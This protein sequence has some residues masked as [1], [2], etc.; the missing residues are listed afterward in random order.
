MP[1]MTVSPRCRPGCIAGI[2]MSLTSTSPD[3]QYFARERDHLSP[4]ARDI[5]PRQHRPRTLSRRLRA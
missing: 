2:L 3:S 4:V 1:P 5:L